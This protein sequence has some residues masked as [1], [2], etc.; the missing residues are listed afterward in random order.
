M[1]EALS[2]KRTMIAR[3]IF[4]IKNYSIQRPFETHEQIF[5]SPSP[6]QEISREKKHSLWLYEYWKKGAIF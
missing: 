3:R 4:F 6:T 2:C 1:F 5:S